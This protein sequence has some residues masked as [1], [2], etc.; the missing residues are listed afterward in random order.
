MHSF[1]VYHSL[2]KN[3]FATMV[4][5]DNTSCYKYN[6]ILLIQLSLSHPMFTTNLTS[7]S[8]R[9]LYNSYLTLC[10][11]KVTLSMIYIRMA[12]TTVIDTIERL[13]DID[14]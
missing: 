5:Y 11:F 14:H 1:I 7:S 2:T 8:I 6:G 9:G 10:A 3:I 13:L 4:H 12:N